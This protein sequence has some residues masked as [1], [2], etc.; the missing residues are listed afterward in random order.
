MLFCPLA[1]LIF[2]DWQISNTLAVNCSGMRVRDPGSCLNPRVMNPSDGSG[3]LW[4]P[5][6]KLFGDARKGSGI[7]SES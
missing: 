1:V 2:F 4:Y 6:S 5:R 7:L 3:N